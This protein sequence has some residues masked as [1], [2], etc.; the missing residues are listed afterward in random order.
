MSDKSR[1]APPADRPAEPQAGG[2]LGP[3]LLLE[4]LG[5]GGMGRVFRAFDE[6]QDRDVAVK[7]MLPNVARDQGSTQL[8]QPGQVLG[9][10]GFMAP[11]Q[12]AGALVDHRCDQYQLGCVLYLLCTGRIARGRFRDP[13]AVNPAVPRALSELIVRLLAQE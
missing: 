5:E 8:T 3:Y 13:D 2:Y 10:P 12:L 7:L 11:E 1:L 4:V 9:T 6:P